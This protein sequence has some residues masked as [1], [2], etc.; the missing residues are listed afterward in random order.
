MDSVPDIQT[1]K[2][3]HLEVCLSED[4]GFT[5]LTPGFERYR[6]RYQA[7]PE[8][9]LADVDLTTLFLGKRLRAPFL[10]GAMTGGEINGARI[11]RALAQAAERLGVGMML[12]SQRVMLERPEAR[13]SFQV[14]DVAPSVLLVGNLGLAQL[15]KGYG[16]EEL[17]QAVSLVGADALALHTNPLQEALQPGG[18]TDF[19]GLLAKLETL[20]PKLPFPVLLKEVGHGIGRETASLLAGLPIAALDVAGAGGTSWAKVEEL[21]HYGRVLHPELV[22]MG[23]PTAEALVECR[24]SLPHTP[25][26]ASGGIRSGTDAAKALAL[27]ADVVAVARPLLKPALEGPEAVVAWIENFLHELRVA[28]YA[29]GAR[30]PQEARGRIERM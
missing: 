12:G 16:P 29:L 27:G 1:R 21:V 14:R 13:S 25:L 15:N 23:I 30:T 5:R 26:V 3:R 22:E 20:L 24:E 10:I 17:R 18:D 2:R 28:L 7:F 6:L 19:R 4:V 8:L 11:N 9:A